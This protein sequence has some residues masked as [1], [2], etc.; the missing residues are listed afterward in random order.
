MLKQVQH[1]SS[2]LLQQFFLHDGVFLFFLLACELFCREKVPRQMRRA[3]SPGIL[4]LREWIFAFFCKC[5]LRRL[6]LKQEVGRRWALA[7]PEQLGIVFA[8]WA[9]KKS[10]GCF[11][12]SPCWKSKENLYADA[13]TSS[14]WRLFLLL[15]QFFLHDGVF[16]SNFGFCECAPVR[17]GNVMYRTILFFF[18]E[19]FNVE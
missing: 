18:I 13:E 4:I 14:A 12:K 1:D 8:L 17:C 2:L 15:Q 11:I 19:Y 6:V 5:S 10:S 7:N 16:C 9:G 3:K